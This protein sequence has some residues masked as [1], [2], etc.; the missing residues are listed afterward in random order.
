GPHEVG[1]TFAIAALVAAFC[2]VTAVGPLSQ[3]FG[4]ARILAVGMAL[5]AVSVLLLTLAQNGR[6]TIGL[7]A[8]AAFGQAIAWPNV[9]GLI[10]R[11]SDPCEQGACLGLNNASAALS[12]LSGPFAAGTAFSLI[13]ANAP[14]WLGALLVIPAIGLSLSARR[15]HTHVAA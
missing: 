14:F 1:D 12:R 7:M 5:T 13:G 3:R 6:V 11:N 8:A 10:S 2:Q 4:A 15:I 9:A